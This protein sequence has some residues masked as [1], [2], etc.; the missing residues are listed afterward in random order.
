MQLILSN[1]AVR[2][3]Q[4]CIKIS[5]TPLGLDTTTLAS[6]LELYSKTALPFTQCDAQLSLIERHRATTVSDEVSKD[7]I[8]LRYKRN[9]LQHIERIAFEYTTL[10]N[11]NCAHCRNG[12]I[13]P[14]TEG[15]PDKLK[16]VVDT[17][18]PLGINR[19]DFIGGEVLLYGARWLDVVNHIRSYPQTTVSVISSGWFFGE[20][21]FRAS[22]VLYSDHNSLL[23]NLKKNGVTHVVISLD[24][25]AHHHDKTRGVPGL[26]DRVI[27]GFDDIRKAGLHPQVSIVLSPQIS[28]N[29]LLAWA[30]SIAQEIY[31]TQFISPIA[32]L[33]KISS[34]SRN[35][36]SNFVDTGNAVRLRRGRADML[37]WDDKEIRCKNFFRPYPSLRV[38]AS[39]EVSLCPLVDSGEGYGNVHQRSFI[40]ILNTLQDSLIY[41]LHANNEIGSYRKYLNP[42]I[43]GHRFDHICGLRTILSMLASRIHQNNIDTNDP[44]QLLAVNEEVARKAGFLP[45]LG[46]IS[47]GANRPK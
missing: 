18:V 33:Q 10:C 11:L 16:E 30:S 29:E 1:Y 12:H 14:K 34:D 44:A 25:P 40:T 41:Q 5:D 31:Q 38:Q 35:Y 32:A 3:L 46:K 19:F 28:G 36:V 4:Q 47:N 9:P 27:K 15:N 17:V 7:A 13:S 42:E 45:P 26:H 21:N 6:L 8:E 22:G 43:F 39:G 23:Q 2:L 37:N 20:R 24:G